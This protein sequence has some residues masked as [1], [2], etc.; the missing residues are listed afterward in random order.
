VSRSW[1]NSWGPELRFRD[2][3][4]ENKND[5]KRNVNKEEEEVSDI[6][7]VFVI[8][9]EWADLKGNTSSEVTGGRWFPSEDAAWGALDLIAEAHGV[10]LDPEETSLVLETDHQ[11]TGL[12]TEEY[13]IEELSRD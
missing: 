4:T 12:S 11:K 3:R 2:A 13:R 1:R 5:W 10:D 6:V 7:R 8:V 9:N